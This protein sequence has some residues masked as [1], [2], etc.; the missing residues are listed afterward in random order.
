MYTKAI[1]CFCPSSLP[2]IYWLLFFLCPPCPVTDI[3]ATWHRS[4][5]NLGWWYISVPDRASP[6]LGA[7]PLRDLPNPKFWVQIVA[8]PIRG[9][10]I[11]SGLGGDEIFFCTSKKFFCTPPQFRHFGGD[12]MTYHC[13][14]QKTFKTQTNRHIIINVNVIYVT[15]NYR[16]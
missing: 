3:S 1:N 9:V 7:V 8:I 16:Q 12:L 15:V 10:A 14:G 5:W 4:A 2:A 6:M 13:T 11:K